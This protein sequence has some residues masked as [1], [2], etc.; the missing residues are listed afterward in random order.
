MAEQE[1]DKKPK[2]RGK[3]SQKPSQKTSQKTSR[4]TSQKDESKG[5][6]QDE[7]QYGAG[8]A[9]DNRSRSRGRKERGQPIRQT[10][11]PDEAVGDSPTDSSASSSAKNNPFAEW[12]KRF[13]G[14]QNQQGV[15]LWQFGSAKSAR[16]R[17]WATSSIDESIAEDFQRRVRS[18][19]FP[20]VWIL[21][22]VWL[23]GFFSTLLAVLIGSIAAFEWQRMV[24]VRRDHEESHGLFS[25]DI[26][27]HLVAAGSF[28]L[29][30]SFF[31]VPIFATSGVVIALVWLTITLAAAVAVEW[32][33]RV[34]RPATS[35]IQ[36]FAGGAVYIGL[37][38][39]A[40]V[41]LR[42]ISD[43]GGFI[44]W[45]LF[46]VWAGDTAAWFGGRSIGGPK[47]WKRVSPSK[48]W[49]G[50]VSGLVGA[51]LVA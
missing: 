19:A 34:P 40:W 8:S 39:I 41:E 13:A 24:L 16:A 23:G 25:N 6:P 29:F 5:E 26:E 37:A 21:F 38:L 11:P 45:L 31:L 2:P 32:Y 30:L 9:N 44:F 51:G 14:G 43:R 3:S 10:R 27:Q 7:P 22:F 50:A 42:G 28:W 4:K 36:I 12:Q 47:L 17:E 20:L 33:M 1:D 18:L 15:F 49:A 35:R 48:T 46:V